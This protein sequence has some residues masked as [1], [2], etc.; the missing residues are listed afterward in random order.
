MEL[1][2]RFVYALSPKLLET[3]GTYGRWEGWVSLCCMA[4]PGTHTYGTAI[5]SLR[6]YQAITAVCL[7]RL[8]T[9]CRLLIA[10]VNGKNPTKIVVSFAVCFFGF[11]VFFRVRFTC[12]L[13]DLM[14]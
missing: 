14:G 2:T 3:G 11:G 10:T 6:C 8:V 1:G 5:A 9:A 12:V 4:V 13:A 7:G